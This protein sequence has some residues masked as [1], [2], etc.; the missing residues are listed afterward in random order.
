MLKG[1]IRC[2]AEYGP[3]CCAEKGWRHSFETR[4]HRPVF[5]LRLGLEHVGDKTSPW[6]LF[7]FSVF[8][9]S[10]MPILKDPTIDLLVACLASSALSRVEVNPGP[11]LSRF[12][13]KK[14]VRRN[15]LHLFSSLPPFL[16]PPSPSASVSVPPNPFFLPFPLL[17][18]IR[19]TKREVHDWPEWLVVILCGDRSRFHRGYCLNTL[20]TPARPGEDQ[21]PRYNYLS[22]TRTISGHDLTVASLQSQS[23]GHHH[24]GLA[25]PYESSEISSSMRVA[26]LL[27][28]GA[29]PLI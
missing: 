24:L 22:P 16:L 29:W 28:T 7:L 17:S 25:V 10:N 19:Y 20:P 12:P 23:I 15:V 2:C 11:G 21:A 1:A 18:H 4:C 8:L 6:T 9:E 3:H 26:A 5:S 27:F 13:P 14:K